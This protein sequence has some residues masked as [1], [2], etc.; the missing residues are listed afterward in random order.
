[1]ENEN[2]LSFTDYIQNLPVKNNVLDLSFSSSSN[3]SRTT[4]YRILHIT[5]NKKLSYVTGC[6]SFILLIIF[7]FMLRILK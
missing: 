4:Y 5:S 1:M 7:L 6:C 2:S 3:Y